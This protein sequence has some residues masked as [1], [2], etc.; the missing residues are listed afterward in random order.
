MFTLHTHT[1]T[2]ICVRSCVHACLSS[3]QRTTNEWNKLY[4]DCVTVSSM[5][6]F[7]NKVVTYLRTAGYT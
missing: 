1:H 5:N 6:M 7:K 3:P 2:H 4:T